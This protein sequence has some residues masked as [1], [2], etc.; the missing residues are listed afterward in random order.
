MADLH[1]VESRLRA[2][3][4]P[5]RAQLIVSKEGPEGMYLELPGYEAR[6]GATWAGLASGRP[7]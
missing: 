2:I 4:E 1:E 5:Y 7:M 3:F 6:R